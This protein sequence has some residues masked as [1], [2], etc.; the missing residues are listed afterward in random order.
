M[1]QKGLQLLGLRW[2]VDSDN[3]A[4]FDLHLIDGQSVD[5]WK[6]S[7]VDCLLVT[8]R[9]NKQGFDRRN[10]RNRLTAVAL[11]SLE[12][13]QD[14]PTLLARFPIRLRFLP[15]RPLRLL[16]LAHPLQPPIRPT[17]PSLTTHHWAP[18][19]SLQQLLQSYREW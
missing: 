17:H 14:Q 19:L 15:I 3:D 8:R 5:W 1:N 11:R 7:I 2:N 13:D 10:P 16:D 12:S 6:D 4:A 9:A 18:R